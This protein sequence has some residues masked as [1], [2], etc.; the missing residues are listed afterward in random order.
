MVGGGGLTVALLL[1]GTSA[2]LATQPSNQQVTICHATNSDDHPSRLG[3]DRWVAAIGARHRVLAQG[4]PRPALVVMVGTAV[5]V[6]AIDAS[7]RFLGGL[8]LPGFGLL[9]EDFRLAVYLAD[10]EG[11]PYKE[12]AEIMDTP[13]GTVMSRLHRGRRQLRELL[14]DYARGRGITV[15]T[16]AGR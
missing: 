2:A 13:I 15:K 9:P 7:G 14:A 3:V 10:V 11:F 1:G 16:G 4:K 8:I 5:T 6:D 12:I